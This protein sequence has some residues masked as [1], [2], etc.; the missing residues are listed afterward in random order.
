MIQLYIYIYSCCSVNL[1]DPMDCSTPG[2]PVLHHLPE[3]A[4]THA[5][6]VGDA[7]QPSH[8]LSPP[9]PPASIFPNIRSVATSQLFAPGGHGVGASALTSVL[10]MNIQGLFPLGFP[11]ISSLSKGLSRVFS[12]TKVIYLLQHHPKFP[13]YPYS[14]F[15]FGDHKFVFYVCKSVSAS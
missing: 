11:L 3:F 1:C 13:I 15:H 5:H 9:S 7:I 14:P 4:Q 8:P 6:W 2:L 10:P 12:R